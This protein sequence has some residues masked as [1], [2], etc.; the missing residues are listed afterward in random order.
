MTNFANKA[1]HQ[2][3]YL[4]TGDHVERGLAPCLNTLHG[5]YLQRETEGEVR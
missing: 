3:A 2:R 5:A 1:Y 4:K